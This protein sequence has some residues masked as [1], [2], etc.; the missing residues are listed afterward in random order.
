MLLM[1]VDIQGES[2]PALESFVLATRGSKATYQARHGQFTAAS[3]ICFLSMA[4]ALFC[5]QRVGTV[6]RETGL[7]SD[8]MWLP[9]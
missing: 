1:I 5:F 6:H 9:I 2:L 8:L 3:V 4:R 7:E